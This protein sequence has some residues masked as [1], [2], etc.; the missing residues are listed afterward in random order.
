MLDNFE[1]VLAAA[2]A[3]VEPAGRGARP[4]AARDEPH[5]APPQR[6]ARLPRAAARRCAEAGRALRRAGPGR[7]RR[8]RARPTRTPRPSP[9]SA[10]GSTACR[11]RSSWR[12]RACATLTPQA[13]LRRLD[14]R[15]P[16]LTGGA[17]DADERQR[18]L[19]DTIA[20]S[21]DL[22]LEREQAL[23]RRLG[24]FV[25]GLPARGGGGRRDPDGSTDVLD[26]L[27]SLVEKSL[28]L[29]LREDSDGEPR[30]WM[31]E[32]I[33]EYALEQL[34]A[35]GELESAPQAARRL[36]RRARRVPGRGVA[37]PATSRRRW[38]ASPTTTRTCARRSSVPAR[39]GTA[40]C[41]CASRR[42]SGR[43]GR[44]AATWPRDGRRSRT[45]SSSPAAA[46]PGRCWACARCGSSA[47]TATGSSTT[48]RRCCAPPR[49]SA[50][51]S[52]SPRRGT[53][54]AASRG[55][56]SGSLARAE[57]AWQQA[58]EHAE[59][60]NLP[61]ERAESIGWLMMAANFGPLPVEEGIAR[62]RR[63]HDEAVDDPFI[64]GNACV[65]LGA[66]EAMRGDFPLGRELVA[67]GPA[68]RSPTSGSRCARR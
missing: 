19:R 54:S 28:L 64:R 4:E 49:S 59:R 35:A 43:S 17:Q 18:T 27:D 30:F 39:T 36:V 47:A 37:R 10:A 63:F 42:R 15:L 61:T 41:C 33:R 22:L 66:L 56:S 51:R 65:E 6:R 55:R 32:T 58:L 34:E 25:G 67:R 2:P 3:L 46:R 68:T 7:R 16:L 52:R 13:L 24:V 20:W 29:R 57:E 50:T 14:Q 60:G 12:R 1:Q 45:H 31:L 40:S 53:C 11:S 26:D 9:R 23:F 5:A 21:Y 44:R 62:C 8:L 38:P 48:S